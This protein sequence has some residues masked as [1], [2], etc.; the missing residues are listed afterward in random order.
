MLA[1]PRFAAPQWSSAAGDLGPRQVLVDPRFA[2]EV[3]DPFPEDVAHDLRRAPLDGVG[4]DPQEAP[5]DIDLQFFTGGGAR[6]R[7]YV[8]GLRFA[9]MGYTPGQA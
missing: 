4:T 5:A 3:E 9:W 6:T 7:T 1:G 8:T 2:G